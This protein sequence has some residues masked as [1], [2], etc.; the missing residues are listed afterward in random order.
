M[1]E[2]RI[3]LADTPGDFAHKMSESI[4]HTKDLYFCG[5]VSDGNAVVDAVL[6]EKPNVL[7]LELMLPGCD[8]LSIIRQLQQTVAHGW[9]PA[10]PVIIVLS[11]IISESN[12][13]LLRNVGID[14]YMVKPIPP[15]SVLERVR[16]LLAVHQDRMM[17]PTLPAPYA[18]MAV[19]ESSDIDCDL[20]TLLIDIGIPASLSG[21][22]YLREAIRLVIDLGTTPDGLLSKRIYPEIAKKHGKSMASVEKAIRTAIETAWLRGRTDVLDRLFGY[23]ISA[24]RGK[25][26]NT[27]F[28]AMIAD[29]YAVYGS[30]R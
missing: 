6:R 15:Q 23:T 13:C 22:T 11:G 28:I 8:G 18:P 9:L 12:T 24:Q 19:A 2:P 17:K 1:N 5:V 14:Y 27:E 16:D 21:Y 4:L 25:P 26:T 3:L 20:T 30:V 10:L 29:R 7:L